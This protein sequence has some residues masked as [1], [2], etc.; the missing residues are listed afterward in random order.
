M[1]ASSNQEV[2]SAESGQ[3]DI[4]DAARAFVSERLS[5][6]ARASEISFALAYVA[7]ELGL[8]VATDRA[9]VYPVVMAAIAEAAKDDARL[10]S[11]VEAAG[12]AEGTEDAIEVAPHATVH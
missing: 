11:E 2:E 1:S 6:G 9:D 4:Y 12:E 10:E 5:A 7:V 3:Q 8:V